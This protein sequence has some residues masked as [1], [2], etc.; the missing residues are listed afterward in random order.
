MPS[1]R[2]LYAIRIM[3]LRAV[4]IKECFGFMTLFN[5]SKIGIRN[6]MLLLDELS[7]E[8]KIINS[9]FEYNLKPSTVKD[10]LKIFRS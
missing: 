1:I 3:V 7:V 4:L 2:T 10:V 9:G 6:M 5:S 8:A